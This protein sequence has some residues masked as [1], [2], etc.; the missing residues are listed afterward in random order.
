MLHPIALLDTCPKNYSRHE[1]KNMVDKMDR[2]NFLKS[3]CALSLLSTSSIMAIPQNKKIL[4]LGGTGFLG[5]VIVEELLK[6]G[7]SVTLFNRGKT[8]PHLFPKLE[9]LR[10]DRETADGSGLDALRQDKR[11]WDWVVDTWQGSSKS[12][13]D[14]AQLLADKVAQ[15]Q[16][17]STISVY[18][19]WDKIGI[20]ESEPLNPLPDEKE[21]IITDNRYAIRKTFSEKI[22]S[23]L[24]P[25]RSVLFRSHGMRGARTTRP[26]HEPYWQVKILRGGDLVLPADTTYY[27]ITDMVSLSRF[28]IH[29]GIKNK[30]GPYNVCYPPFLFRDFIQSIVDATNSK[31]NLHYI[32]QSFLRANDVKLMY[33]HNK[34]PGRYRFDVTKALTAGLQNRSFEALLQDQLNGYFERNP[35]GGF[36]FGHPETKTITS[37]KEQVII[38]RWLAT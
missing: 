34:R 19:K 35:N 38:Q 31:V 15:Y 37:E 20:V 18:D 10:G 7:Y 1:S 29:C 14:T 26:I 36:A 9:K 5:P 21:G 32:P 3:S 30:L 24:L 12:V 16:Y 6:Q 27:Q 17:V 28:M 2:R 22:L 23:E 13:A 11:R 33:D 4:V 8:N 25:D